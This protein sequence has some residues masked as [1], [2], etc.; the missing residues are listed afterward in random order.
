MP[1][2]KDTSSKILFGTHDIK[3]G[4]LFPIYPQ[5]TGKEIEAGDWPLVHRGAIQ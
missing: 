2:E 1:K 5:F 4:S 3:P